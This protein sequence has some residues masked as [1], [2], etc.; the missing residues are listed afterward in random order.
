MKFGELSIKEYIE[1]LSS[2][3]SVPGGGSALALVL[4]LA[5]SLDLM[6]ANFTLNKKG[7][8]EFNQE[9]EEMID[10]LLV[11]RSKA[12]ELIDLD[13][14]AYQRVIDAYRSKDQQLISLASI[15][16]CEIPFQL[17]NLTRKCEEVCLRILQIGNKNLLSDAR[18]ALKLCQSIYDG[19]L[20]NIKCNIEGILD[21]KVKQKY[22][23]IL[24]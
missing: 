17:Y 24:K 11:M 3:Q 16:G 13:G 15:N 21:S 22:Q 20:D 10:S 14:M 7:Y 12:H 6:V 8:E 4:E 1:V 9:I 5:I 23:E 18:I 19:C 2:K